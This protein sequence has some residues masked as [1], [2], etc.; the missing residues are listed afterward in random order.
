MDHERCNASWPVSSKRV[1][2]PA[3]SVRV[4]DTAS[5]LADNP[6]LVVLDTGLPRVW[7]IL[8]EL[9]TTVPGLPIVVVVK[10]DGEESERLLLAHA[11]RCR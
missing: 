7:Q 4:M 3:L 10:Q 1:A 2:E 5:L 11:P 9:R 6:D 8:N